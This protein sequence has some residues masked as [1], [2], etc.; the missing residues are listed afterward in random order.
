MGIQVLSRGE[1]SRVRCKS[2]KGSR[3]DPELMFK[4]LNREE[5]PYKFIYDGDP[6]F[7]S[8]GE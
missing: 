2:G 6:S 4:L 5:P 3:R 7:T 1:S 8:K